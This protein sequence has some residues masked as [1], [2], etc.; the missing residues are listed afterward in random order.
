MELFRELIGPDNGANTA[1]L[2]VRAVIIFFLG[3]AYIRI[4]GR[5]TFSNASPL[6]IVVALVVGS[7]LS[8]VMTGK[9]DFWPA[10]TASLLLVILHRVF[11]TLTT[12]WGWLAKLMKAEPVV[13]VRDGTADRK[14]M[15]WHG[16]G[17]M[18]LREGLRLEQVETPEEV[19]LATLENSGRI[20]VVP[21]ARRS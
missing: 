20:S 14:A 13:L 18:D 17:D 16:I 19:R 2:C 5:R 15:L 8:R 7:N 3:V 9:A 4:A 1:Q 10:I 6:D 21:K 11:A 12:H